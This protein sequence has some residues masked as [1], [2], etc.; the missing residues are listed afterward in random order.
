MLIVGI[1]AFGQLNYYSAN[2]SL[3]EKMQ[4]WAGKFYSSYID[5]TLDTDDLYDLGGRQYKAIGTWSYKDRTSAFGSTKQAKFTAWL[6][7][8]G[9]GRAQVKK[10]CIREHVGQW[11]SEE[12][13]EFEE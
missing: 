5:G 9:S 7:V 12:C 3:D 6:L 4:D 1:N 13:K 2:Q 10:I 11:K 8:R